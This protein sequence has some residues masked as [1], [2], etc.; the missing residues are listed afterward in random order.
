MLI[1]LGLSDLST[2]D[3]KKRFEHVIK[4]EFIKCSFNEYLTLTSCQSH[5]L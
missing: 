5:L 1:L 4:S 2:F 3:V